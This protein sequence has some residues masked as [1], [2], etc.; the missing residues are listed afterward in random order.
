MRPGGVRGALLNRQYLSLNATQPGQVKDVIFL[1]NITN[2]H[3]AQLFGLLPAKA[4]LAKI[5][6]AIE[7]MAGVAGFCLIHFF[8]ILVK[9]PELIFL[10]RFTELPTVGLE[11]LRLRR[12]MPVNQGY[13]RLSLLLSEGHDT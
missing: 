4:Q 5:Q 8:H 9:M 10:L 7:A 13:D 1:N 11:G 3:G 6:H 2:R 12:V